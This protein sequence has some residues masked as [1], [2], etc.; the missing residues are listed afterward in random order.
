[1]NVIDPDER[2][3]K[4]ALSCVHDYQ[5]TWTGVKPET[6]GKIE[7]FDSSHIQDAISDA[8]MVVEAVPE[9][10]SLKRDIVRDLDLV[11]SKDT[12][13]ASNSSSYTVSE[14]IKDQG[15]RHPERAVS[16][17]AYWPPE[18]SSIEVMGHEGTSESVVE[19]LMTECK[20]HGF[21]PYRVK[22]NSTGYLYNRYIAPFCRNQSILSGC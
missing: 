12:I 4:A 9:R 2:Q 10:L 15:L 6:W 13:L 7:T 14:I 19:T 11:A 18:T 17:H 21:T 3:L 16:L 22:R 20:M 5:K 8:W 1:M